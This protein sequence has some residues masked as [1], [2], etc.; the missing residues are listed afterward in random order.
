MHFFLGAGSHGYWP[1]LNNPALRSSQEA[2]S[3]Q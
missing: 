1:S 2:K 3:R